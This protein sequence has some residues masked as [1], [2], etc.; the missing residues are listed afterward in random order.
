MRKKVSII[1]SGDVGTNTALFIAEKKIAD[2]QLIDTRGSGYDTSR[3]PGAIHLRPG[4][5]ATTIDG[6]A[7]QVIPPEQAEQVFDRF[8]QI[9]HADGSKPQGSGLG[10]AITRRIVEYHGGS[11]VVDPEVGEGASF[12]IALPVVATPP[13][14]LSATA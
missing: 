13:P 6:V 8:H 3:I 10:L 7:S 5:L 14:E 9:A 4:E 2:V 12:R 1:G 11:I